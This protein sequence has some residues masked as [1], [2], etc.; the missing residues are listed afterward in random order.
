LASLFYRAAGIWVVLGE[1]SGGLACRDYDVAASYEKW[2]SAH[3]DLAGVL[4]TVRTS[5]GFHVYFRSNQEGEHNLGDGEI[6]LS[7]CGTLLP[8]SIHPDGHRYSWLIPP[9]RENLVHIEN[10][11]VFGFTK[12]DSESLYLD[13][14]TPESTER[15]DENRGD[16]VCGGGGDVEVASIIEKTLPREPGTRH[17]RLFDLARHLQSSPR[18]AGVRPE[19]LRLIVEEWHRRALPCIRTKPFAESWIDFL[20]AWPKVH[21]TIGEGPMA[22]VF[23][24]AL[25]SSPP[26]VAAAKYPGHRELQLLAALCRELQRAAGDGVFFISCR[27]AGELLGVSQAQAGRWLWLLNH[28]GIIRTIQ[29]GGTAKSARRAT[30]YR[31]MEAI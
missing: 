23:E 29:K 13:A 2:A 14:E 25:L 20:R 27:K 28:D 12:S 11:S 10:L 15:T 26:A 21:S 3:P 6:R 9:T 8:P 19:T 5:R 24:R 18:F 31:Y 1:V 7:R 4:P 16:M 17:R 22:K 30:R